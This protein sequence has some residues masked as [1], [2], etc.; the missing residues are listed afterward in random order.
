MRRRALLVVPLLVVVTVAASW[1]LK[2]PS[3]RPRA[4]QVRPTD[5]LVQN[6]TPQAWGNIEVWVNDR[7]RG[8]MAS[9]SPGQVLAVPL[10]NMVAAYG[11]RFN[12]HRQAVYGV[13]VIAR[14]SDGSAVRLTWGTVRRK[15]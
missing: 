15:W 2:E 14:A 5:I 7:Y 1:L 13:L 6:Q 8:V 3:E 9:L 12:V 10:D 4:I 11:Q